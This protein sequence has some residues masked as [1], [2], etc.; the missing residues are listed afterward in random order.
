MQVF[1]TLDFSIHCRVCLGQRNVILYFTAHAVFRTLSKLYTSGPQ[2]YFGEVDI[3]VWVCV[4]VCVCLVCVCVCEYLVCVCVCVCL[5]CVCV[6]VCVCVSGV[7]CHDTG[8]RALS[9]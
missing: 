1:L 7:L 6:C 8:A 5:V 4:C 9:C 2:Q 3:C